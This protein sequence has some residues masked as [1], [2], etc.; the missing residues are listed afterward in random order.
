[1]SDRVLSAC[2]RGHSSVHTEKAFSL[3]KKY[4]FSLTAQMMI[5][6]PASTPNDE[7]NTAK[8][9]IEM[10]ADSA[11]I[12][13]TV[14]LKETELADMT[15]RN[16]YYPLSKDDAV[17]RTADVLYEFIKAD[18]PVIR[19][20][21][22]AQDNLSTERDLYCDGYD[23]AIGEYAISR[24]YERLICE[25]LSAFT[26]GDLEGKELIVFASEG[27]TSKIVGH[28]ATTKKNIISAY[29]LKSLKV[30]EKSDIL[31]YNINIAI[32]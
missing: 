22:C 17:T 27:C 18:V 5:G 19:I 29:S 1:M 13:P 12:Y 21:L 11:R 30:I 28:K 14:V 7:I 16:D 8:K 25:K 24:V 15:Q 6:L 3:I 31:G 32:N 2:K 23:E 9:V 10:G 26:K 4:G 20:G